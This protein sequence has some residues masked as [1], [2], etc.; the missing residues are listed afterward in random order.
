MLL[1]VF[2]SYKGAR[3]Y[4]NQ[5]ANQT[6]RLEELE[7]LT[8]E[9]LT[10]FLD[11]AHLCATSPASKSLKLTSS[12]SPNRRSNQWQRPCGYLPLS[13]LYQAAK[14]LSSLMI[15]FGTQLYS[16][17][18]VEQTADPQVQGN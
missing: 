15:T 1:V 14:N 17:V 6:A 5:I 18:I 9:Q 8:R 11:E 13:W 10:T 7:V 2:A 4:L 16:R 12:T 3:P